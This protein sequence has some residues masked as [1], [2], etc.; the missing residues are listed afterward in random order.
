[1][2]HIVLPLLALLVVIGAGCAYLKHDVACPANAYCEA[3][4]FGGVQ[5]TACLSLADMN[6]L[7]AIAADR[8]AEW[9]KSNGLKDGGL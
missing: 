9:M 6:K 4:D 3:L 1:M 5:L 7:K 8:K 2:K